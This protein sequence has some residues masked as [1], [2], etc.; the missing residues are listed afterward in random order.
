VPRM[1]VSY[2]GAGGKVEAHETE[3]RTLTVG[4]GEG[5]DLRLAGVAPLEC[6]IY[7]SE[8]GYY[9]RDDGRRTSINGI[10]GPGFVRPNDVIQLGGAVALR[11][12]IVPDT[13]APQVAVHPAPARPVTPRSSAPSARAREVARTRRGRSPAVAAL[14]STVFPGAGQAYNGQ[15]AK[16]FLILI[17]AVL[18]LPWLLG[19][20][21]AHHV[22][23]H[24]PAMGGR[25]GGGA[26]G[27]TLHLWLVLDLGL[28]TLLALTVTGVLA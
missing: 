21:D 19:I 5:C 23:A 22:A 6:T 1:K 25:A 15:P 9:V 2:F 28:L 20:W 14:L 17:L 8:Q 11:F 4:S 16:A 18:V 3:A 7:L 13:P 26:W 10:Q 12:E 24:R 27:V